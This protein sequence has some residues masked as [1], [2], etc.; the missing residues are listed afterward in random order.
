[1]NAKFFYDQTYLHICAENGHQEVT[2]ALI[3][4]GADVN[5]KNVGGWT[6]LGQMRFYWTPG[7]RAS[8]DRGG[9]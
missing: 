1:M 5:A 9:S 6:P 2:R 3:E 4:A 7:G 8:L